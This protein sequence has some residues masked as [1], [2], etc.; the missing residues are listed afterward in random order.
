M[1]VQVFMKDIRG[2]VIKLWKIKQGDMREQNRDKVYR[3]QHFKSWPGQDLR[4]GK[5]NINTECWSAGGNIINAIN[6]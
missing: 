4:H 1:Y 6:I 3:K 2:G 5:I